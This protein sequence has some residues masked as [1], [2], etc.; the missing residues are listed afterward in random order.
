MCRFSEIAATLGCSENTVKSRLNYGRKIE[1]KAEELKKKGYKLYNVAPLPL[2]LYLLR[3]QEG[4]LAADGALASAGKSVAATVFQSMSQTGAGGVGGTAGGQAAL[5]SQAAGTQASSGM[6]AA[7]GAQAAS[8]AAAAAKTGLLHTTLGKA[9]V[10][11]VGICLAGGAGFYGASQI[12]DHREEPA[13]VQEE[14]EEPRQQDAQER[15]EPEQEAEETPVEV[16]DEEYPEL[17]AGN[18]TKEELEYVLA[19][20]PQESPSQDSQ[21]RTWSRF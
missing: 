12:M 19:Y 20:G 2:L 17:I 13:A 6:Q 3:T 10:V 4:Y 15:Q 1:K 5:G 21:S 9:A 16:K 8:K 18:L 7:S 14:R 11:V